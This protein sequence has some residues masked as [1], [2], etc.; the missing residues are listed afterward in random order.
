VRVERQ[1]VELRNGT[2][3]ATA[4]KTDAG[5]RTVHP[6]SIG[7]TLAA[8]LERHCG[9]DDSDLVFTRPLSEG[10]RHATL[11]TEWRRTVTK[12]GLGGLHL[13]DLRH[14]AGTLAAQTGATTRELMARLGHA[15]SAA[16]ER[17]QH[18]AERRDANIADKLET[19][20]RS[21][22][23]DSEMDAASD[24]RGGSTPKTDDPK[25]PEEGLAW[26]TA[27]EGPGTPY[28]YGRD[29][30][31][32][33]HF[34]ES[35]RRESNPRSQLGNSI[36]DVRTHPGASNPARRGSKPTERDDSGQPGMRHDCAIDER[37]DGDLSWID[38]I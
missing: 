5:V 11:Y 12:I 20:L 34:P 26:G 31:S 2:R 14:A 4:P 33:Q 23:P 25:Q 22:R 7:A 3:I 28:R 1:T 18:A 17:C 9:T 32:D 37:N 10:L 38:W 21:V 36:L 6:P 24:S 8:H 13:H 29:Y 35:E 27:P 30:S 15:S 16:A 19:V